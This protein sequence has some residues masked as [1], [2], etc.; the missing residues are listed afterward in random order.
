MPISLS[1]PQ[2]EHSIVRFYLD[3]R[4]AP[5]DNADPGIATIFCAEPHGGETFPLD[6]RIIKTWVVDDEGHWI[7]RPAIRLE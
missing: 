3:F 2:F 4:S 7:E 1:T 5:V 6:E